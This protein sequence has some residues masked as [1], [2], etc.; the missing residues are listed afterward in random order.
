M[1]ALLIG[2]S[3]VVLFLALAAFEG[4]LRFVGLGA[5]DASR[6][7]ALKYQQIFLPI[8]EPATRPD[9][10]PVYRTVDSRLPYQTIL[11]VKPANS[12]RVFTLGGSAAAGLGFSPN[13]TFARHLERMLRTAYPKRN[14]E[15]ANLAIVALSSKQ[16]KIL[17]EH[18]CAEFSPDLVVV[19]SG[20]NEFLEVHAEKYAEAN[21]TF[22]SSA[23]NLLSETNLYRVLTRLIHRGGTTPSLAEQNFSHDDLRLT[24]EQIIQDTEMTPKEISAI[25][26]RYEANI[27]QMARSSRANNVPILLMAVASNWEWRGRSDLPDGWLSDLLGV[28]GPPTRERYAQ[29]VRI[30]D[31]KLRN[32]SNGARH[33][34]LFRRAIAHEKL[35]NI[36]A[37]RDD[38]RA[39]MN[40]DPHLR[41]A[42]D[43][44]NERVRRAAARN[45]VAYL[46][47]AEALAR[48]APDG[49]V[50]FDE[51]YDYVHF[52]PRGAVLAA[53]E[54]FRKEIPRL[55]LGVPDP[56]FELE[57]YVRA[58]LEELEDPSEDALSV[59]EWMGFGFDSAGISDRD[60]WKYDKLLLELDE[61]L[62]REPGD[63]RA[64]VYRGNAH[65][66]QVDGAR[67]AARDY[68]AALDTAGAPPEV[69]SNLE[70]LLRERSP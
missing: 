8:L 62:T 58:E 65:F 59:Y 32:G 13:V 56:S 51:F 53:A 29:A 28:P 48:R 1:N 47:T 5:P 2:G 43:A 54:I 31:E 30:L 37:A 19:Y 22:V 35:G 11:R 41:R 52:T 4:L 15:M 64:L 36:E 68:R 50:G 9:G 61:R 55:N 57:E 67:Q 60:L 27:D 16:V 26:D 34:H 7:S 17:V 18:V 23:V 20:N 45:G 69:H 46:D 38:Y 10:T 39:A 24:Q 70:A 44:A 6:T 12:L 42:L 25:I 3:V 40:A 66:F 63:V 21:A 49:I 14:V 33:E